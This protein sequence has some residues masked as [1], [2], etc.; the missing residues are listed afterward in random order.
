MGR[1]PTA[2]G[3]GPKGHGGRSSGGRPGNGVPQ[4]SRPRKQGA[5]CTPNTRLHRRRSSAKVHKTRGSPN[6]K[7]GTQCIRKAYEIVLAD[8]IALPKADR[9]IEIV[10][11]TL[12]QRDRQVSQIKHVTDKY[13]DESY[14]RQ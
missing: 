12:L 4:T 11:P 7:A 1:L 14:Y 2:G 9:R 8:H 13:R 3:S 10:R 6:S 5:G